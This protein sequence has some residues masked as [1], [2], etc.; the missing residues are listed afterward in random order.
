MLALCMSCSCMT[1]L[2]CGESPKDV[3]TFLPVP[4]TWD[5][6][7]STVPADYKKANPVHDRLDQFSNSKLV[8]GQ[9]IVHTSVKFVDKKLYRIRQN[10]SSKLEDDFTW[11]QSLILKYTELYGN[12]SISRPAGDTTSDKND[13]TV[14]LLC[15]TPGK[16][17]Y[18]WHFGKKYSVI[19]TRTNVSES[20]APTTI[21]FHLEDFE[22][23]AHDS[24]SA[25]AEI[26]KR[27]QEDERLRREKKRAAGN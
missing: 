7:P 9:P 4:M 12:P 20:K 23:V 15:P 25:F 14:N 6:D 13:K 27:I 21:L 1:P 8:K 19:I 11:S 16:Y 3:P 17:V 24:D 22:V 26:E 5:S 2:M 18:T 10:L